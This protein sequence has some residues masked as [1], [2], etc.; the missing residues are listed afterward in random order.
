MGAGSAAV[1]IVGLIFV[2]GGV[3]FLPLAL[4]PL[5]AGYAVT[6]ATRLARVF[7]VS[8]AVL[9]GVVVAYVATYPLRGLPPPP[10]QSA[11]IDP[12]SLL[13]AAVFLTAA[14]LILVG[15]ARREASG[16]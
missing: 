5:A 3:A 6:R 1:A 9:Y 2:G 13:V 7:A 4:P 11:S 10:G 12:G 8:V 14:L 16:R 15:S